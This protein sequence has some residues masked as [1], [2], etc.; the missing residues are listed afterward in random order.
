VQAFSSEDEDSL[1]HPSNSNA[2]TKQH[3][4]AM[5]RFQGLLAQG[6]PFTLMCLLTVVHC[7]WRGCSRGPGCSLGDWCWVA[8]HDLGYLTIGGVL[9]DETKSCPWPEE[10]EARTV[11]SEAELVEMCPPLPP[12]VEGLECASP[13]CL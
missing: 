2:A 4:A 12:E 1:K 5:E 9:R 10:V 8:E 13:S 7:R 11:T 3:A 6:E